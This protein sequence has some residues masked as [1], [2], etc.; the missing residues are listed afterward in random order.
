MKKT[1]FLAVL[2][3]SVINVLSVNSCS[4]LDEDDP[5]MGQKIKRPIPAKSIK[6][7]NISRLNFV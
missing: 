4:F 5:I 7:R 3:I 2:F 6:V 1:L